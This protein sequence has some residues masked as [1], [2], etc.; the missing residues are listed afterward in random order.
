MQLVVN[1]LVVH[2]QKAG[3]GPAVVL[4]HGWGDSADSFNK[5]Q[6]LLAKDYLV[7]T[8]DLPGFGRSQP[9]LN[10]WDLDDYAKFVADFI[11]KV[12]IDQPLALV[13]HSNGGAICIRGLANGTLSADKLVLLASS[14]IRTGKFLRKYFFRAA[15]KVGKAV[16][17]PLPV[18]KRR[19]LRHKLYKAAGSDLL[20]AEHMQD[21]FKR[22]VSQDVQ[23]DAKKLKIPTL[24]VYGHGDT[25][26]PV[27][28]GVR[29]SRLIKNSHLKVLDDADHGLQKEQPDK[30]AQLISDFLK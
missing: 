1:S 28:F 10:T 4:V 27:L 11:D 23:P 22:I 3:K 26:T 18:E 24:L 16:T 9:P 7:Y 8:L 21:T 20:V 5:L 29:F 25:I 19:A 6:V 30:I 17:A 13:G 15:A 12:D 2:Y 14:G